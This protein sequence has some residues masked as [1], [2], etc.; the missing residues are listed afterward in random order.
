MSPRPKIK[1]FIGYPVPADASGASGFVAQ[2]FPKPVERAPW[3]AH[4]KE[5]PDAITAG[6]VAGDATLSTPTTAQREQGAGFKKV[7]G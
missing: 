3:F 5:N 7:A 2:Q 1:N 4:Q 6:S